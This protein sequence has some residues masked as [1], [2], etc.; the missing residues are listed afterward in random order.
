MRDIVPTIPSNSSN[1][2]SILLEKNNNLFNVS[3]KKLLDNQ[4][5]NSINYN[6]SKLNIFK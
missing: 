1:L 4:S 5:E 3:N 2:S 6:E